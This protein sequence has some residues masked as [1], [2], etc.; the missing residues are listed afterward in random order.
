MTKHVAHIKVKCSKRLNLFRCIAGS[1]FGADRKTLLHLYRT[2]VLSI[3][4]YGSVIYSGAIDSTLKNLDTIQNA[5]LRIA[6]GAMKT[7]P[8]PCLQ[9]RGGSTSL[10]FTPNGTVAALHK[11]SFFSSKS[12]HLQIPQYLTIHSPQLSGSGREEI[13]VNDRF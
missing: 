7:S 9:C 4:E 2:L 12:Q 11:Q 6:I 8:I 3:I 10:E 13:W 5:F 1:D